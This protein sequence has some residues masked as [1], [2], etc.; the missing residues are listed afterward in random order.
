MKPSTPHGPR[1][2]RPVKPLDPELERIAK[3]VESDEYLVAPADNPFAY[4]DSRITLLSLFT[5]D[6]KK[7]RISQEPGNEDLFKDR[8]PEGM[9]F[10]GAA[11]LYRGDVSSALDVSYTPDYE[12]EDHSE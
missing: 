12:G 1:E 8:Q 5:P 3:K 6:D 11:A 7:E 10:I 2:K 9:H 4:K